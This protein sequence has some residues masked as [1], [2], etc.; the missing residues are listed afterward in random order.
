[1]VRRIIKYFFPVSAHSV[2]FIIL[3]LWEKTFPRQFQALSQAHLL[4]AWVSCAFALVPNQ[5]T[6]MS[7][8]TAKMGTALKPIPGWES[9]R[10][11]PQE[12]GDAL[13]GISRLWPWLNFFGVTLGGGHVFLFVHVNIPW[14][15]C[16]MICAWRHQ[17]TS[18]L[19]GPGMHSQP[20]SSQ[21]WGTPALPVSS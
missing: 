20:L 7:L 3:N 5:V 9:W 19:T 21:R 14:S 8:S 11:Q 6:Q 4:T 1:M 13:V 2:E 10:V 16:A 15:E 17:Q 12:D 18:V